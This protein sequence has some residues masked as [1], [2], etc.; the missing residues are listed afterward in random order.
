M[1]WF[2]AVACSW[3]GFHGGVE[4][5]EP[6]FFKNVIM[7][8]KPDVQY[9]CFSWTLWHWTATDSS[10]FWDCCNWSS[11]SLETTM[12]VLDVDLVGNLEGLAFPSGLFHAGI[13]WGDW[14]SLDPFS[15]SE[16]RLL[17]LMLSVIS[18]SFCLSCCSS[19]STSS[20]WGSGEVLL[21]VGG[22]WL[23]CWNRREDVFFTLILHLH[24][25]F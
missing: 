13:S 2:M 20:H 9:V 24:V 23:A 18:C 19:R 22:V 14:G 16:V 3:T 10:T 15:S 25:A 4:F 7:C 11:S 8:N 6:C 12:L 5:H 1:T 21:G 17:S